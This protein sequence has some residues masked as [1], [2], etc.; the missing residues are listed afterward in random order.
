M[1]ECKYQQNINGSLTESNCNAVLVQSLNTGRASQ[2]WGCGASIQCEESFLCNLWKKLNIPTIWLLQ[3]FPNLIYK[4]RHMCV[5]CVSRDIWRRCHNSLPRAVHVESWENS[6]NDLWGAFLACKTSVWRCE[7][8]ASLAAEPAIPVCT[9]C[10][11]GSGCGCSSGPLWGRWSTWAP[12][13]RSEGRS[14]PRKAVPAAIRMEEWWRV[15]RMTKGLR[16][17]GCWGRLCATIWQF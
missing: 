9:W 10:E 14:T 8:L 1:S 4:N 5:I 16:R 11:G 15:N 12:C 2:S 6:A 7:L 3:I 17:N 13:V